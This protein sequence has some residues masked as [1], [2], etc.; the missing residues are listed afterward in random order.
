MN[1]GY[2]NLRAGL[3]DLSYDELVTIKVG[4]GLAL[5]TAMAYLAKSDFESRDFVSELQKRIKSM[6]V[7]VLAIDNALAMSTNKLH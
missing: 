4:A 5:E 2:I 3:L 6:A 1:T 7:D